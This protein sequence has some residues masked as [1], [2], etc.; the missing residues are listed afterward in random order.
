[1]KPYRV[2]VFKGDLQVVRCAAQTLNW[3]ST[4][5]ALWRN[6]RNPAYLRLM[7]TLVEKQM[8]TLEY[9]AVNYGISEDRILLGRQ[10]SVCDA[11]RAG[12]VKA[13]ERGIK[14]CRPEVSA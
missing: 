2:L 1:M 9:I 8:Q 7:L 12:L 5:A 3:S 4:F 10:W 6:T 14:V 11:R 13:L